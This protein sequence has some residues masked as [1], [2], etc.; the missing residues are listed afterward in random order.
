M[1]T[2]KN[3]PLTVQ[4]NLRLANAAI[5]ASEASLW[6]LNEKNWAV[7]GSTKDALEGSIAFAKKREPK[8]REC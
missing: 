8:W 2:S 5:G 7:I 3:A 6:L 1:K 4:A